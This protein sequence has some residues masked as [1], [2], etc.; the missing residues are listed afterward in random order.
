MPK[1]PL[2]YRVAYKIS[3]RRIYRPLVKLVK[4][5]EPQIVGVDIGSGCGLAAELIVNFFD[6]LYL[7]DLDEGLARD[8]KK[9]LR[10]HPNVEVIVADARSIPL[11]DAFA[12]LVYFFDS[13]HHIPRPEKALFEAIRILKPKGTLAIFDLDGR[14]LFAKFL[15]LLERAFGLHSKPLSSQQLCSLLSESNFSILDVEVDLFGMLNLYA[16]KER[17][18][19]SNRK[20]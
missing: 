12:D 2:A 17:S 7:I 8:A 18:E 15:S 9:R 3:S 20:R 6:R 14:Q 5:L 4:S 1:T 16:V 13:L 10:F 11:P 19:S